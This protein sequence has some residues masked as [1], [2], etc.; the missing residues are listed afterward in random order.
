[1]TKNKISNTISPRNIEQIK[2]GHKVSSLKVKR[3]KKQNKNIDKE[4]HTINEPE[5]GRFYK[6]VQ[7]HT[8]NQ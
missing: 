3:S 8:N 6:I 1:V 4:N 7:R 5:Q 2:D